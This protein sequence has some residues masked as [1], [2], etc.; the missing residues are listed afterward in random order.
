[1]ALH[2]HRQFQDTTLSSHTFSGSGAYYGSY[3]STYLYAG[4]PPTTSAPT[5]TPVSNAASSTDVL[6]IGI[7]M[8]VIIIVVGAVLAMLLLR[9]KP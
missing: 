6:G 3:A 4:S 8:I 1:M 5:S 7:A 9:K 2:G